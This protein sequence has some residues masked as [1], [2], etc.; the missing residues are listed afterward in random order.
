MCTN[1]ECVEIGLMLNSQPELLPQFGPSCYG[2]VWTQFYR[3]F[4]AHSF[5]V[6]LPNKVILL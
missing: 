5:K 2:C 1:C 6:I 4:F 3:Y